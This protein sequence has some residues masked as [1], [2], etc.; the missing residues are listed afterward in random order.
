MAIET[1]I[2]PTITLLVPVRDEEAN[3]RPFVQNVRTVLNSEEYNVSILFVEDNSSDNTRNVIKTIASSDSSINGLFIN[4]KFGQGPAVFFGL[5]NCTG[6]AVIMM[7]IDGTHPLSVA[8]EMIGK[9]LAGADIVQGVRN[10]REIF[11]VRKILSI[12]FN[13]SC[14][15]FA[16]VDLSMQPVYFRLLSKKVVSAITKQPW[17]AHFVRLNFREFSDCRIEFIE[18]HFIER[19]LG[20]GKYN[21]R[22]LIKLAI[23]GQLSLISPKRL[24]FLLTLLNSIAISSIWLAPLWLAVALMVLAGFATI[25]LLMEFS[26]IRNRDVTLAIQILP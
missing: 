4:N 2:K 10:Q 17:L 20:R 21:L 9:F 8:K 1:T 11:G 13:Y 19:N 18:F 24:Y 7:D 5:M 16:G 26:R 22:G 3:I 23:R 25:F 15:L 12:L 14:R 6:D